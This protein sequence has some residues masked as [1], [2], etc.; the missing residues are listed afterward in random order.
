MMD[1]IRGGLFVCLFR[2]K[3]HRNFQVCQ[4]CFSGMKKRGGWRWVVGG[5]GCRVQRRSEGEPISFLIKFVFIIRWGLHEFK[6]SVLF[7]IVRVFL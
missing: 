5:G 7:L 3:G 4:S 1:K 2:Q 6:F